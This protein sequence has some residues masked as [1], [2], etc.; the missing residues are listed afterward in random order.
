M[1]VGMLGPSSVLCG[2]GSCL[3]D[4]EVKELQ[5]LSVAASLQGARQGYIEG[6]DCR[7]TINIVAHQQA[8]KMVMRSGMATWL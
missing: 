3:L 5:L 6:K 8:E 2:I 7:V 1:S 4:V